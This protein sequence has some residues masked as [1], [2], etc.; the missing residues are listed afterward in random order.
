MPRR[1][2][3]SGVARPTMIGAPILREF[4]SAMHIPGT[5]RTCR[6]AGAA[7]TLARPPL[8]SV[9]VPVWTGRRVADEPARGGA[10]GRAAD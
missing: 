10:D 6:R 2:P 7:T 9:P 8:L 3:G 1:M 4:P 5:I